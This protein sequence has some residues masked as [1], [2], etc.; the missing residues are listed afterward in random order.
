M[1]AMVL[2]A[3]RQLQD[4]G[5]QV[6]GYEI[7][8]MHIKK[9]MIVPNSAHGL[10][11]ALN[12]NACQNDQSKDTDKIVLYAFTVYSK[13]LGASW[14]KNCEGRL[15]IHYKS[16][17]IPAKHIEGKS[18][19]L[20]EIKTKYSSFL[21]TC[22][23]S[24]SPRQLYETLE[25]IGM[26]YGP[27]FQNIISVHKKGSISCTK[28]RIPD[29]KAQM[30]AKYEFPHLIHPATLDATFQT[31]FVAGNEPMVPSFLE[32][33]YIA[34]EFPSGASSELEGYSGASRLGFL[35]NHHKLC[36]EL[37]WKENIDTTFCSSFP[38]WLGLLSFKNPDLPI[39]EISD[40]NGSS[41]ISSLINIL[42]KC[43]DATPGFSRY[44]F[45][46]TTSTHFEAL[47]EKVSAWSSH[48]DW[49]TLDLEES[50]AKQGFKEHDYDIVIIHVVLPDSIPALERLLKLQGRLLHIRTSTANFDVDGMNHIDALDLRIGN[51]LSDFKPE[52]ILDATESNTTPVHSSNN[53]TV[54]GWVKV[55][56]FPSTSLSN[57]AA[58][59]ILILLPRQPS[60]EL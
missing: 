22:S 9:A 12:I 59:E 23:E 15:G 14:I 49:K 40:G 41:A 11:T 17:S 3:A 37:T 32:C 5:R 57:L 44:T 24:I 1:M 13:Q 56:H 47:H 25:S 58:C 54:T 51:D 38:E 34:A 4:E 29:T 39:L 35:P 6:E 42:G 48:T 33:L 27:T 2:E 8:K 10:E 19:Y 45:A 30:P 28:I 55:L 31:I 60:K 36:A 21:G 16:N 7:T 53:K 26:K 18:T 46:D 43:T 50:L 52:Q 20:Q